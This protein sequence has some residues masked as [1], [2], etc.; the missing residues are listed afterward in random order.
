MM[1][2]NLSRE[3]HPAGHVICQIDDPGDCAYLVESGS[4]EVL[5]RSG[6]QLAILRAGEIVGEITQLDQ[7]PRPAT[8][9]TLETTVLLRIDR[10][11]VDEL[12]KRTDPVIRHLLTL[13]LERFRHRSD[14]TEPGEPSSRQATDLATTN[15]TLMMAQDLGYAMHNGQL[16]LAYQPLISLPEQRLLGFEALIRWQHPILGNISPAK[17][18]PLA[19]K[20]GMTEALGQWVLTQGIG[21]W[22]TLRQYCHRTPSPAPFISINLSAPE[23]ANP[24]IVETIDRLLA[25]NRM[26]ASELQLELI[27]TTLIDDMPAVSGNLNQLTAR[28]IGIALDDFGTGYASFEYLSTLPISCLKI[29]QAFILNAT[30][31]KRRREIVQM[32]INLARSLGMSTIGEGIEDEATG[33]LLAELGCNFAQGYF[34]GRPMALAAIPDWLS[35]A[36]ALGRLAP[37]EA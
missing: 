26:Q 17:L 10:K 23:L 19:E 18:I 28:G 37:A 12:L 16:S 29:D 4:I 30:H 3:T 8:I 11:H 21:D 22:P 6:K 34:F 25:A 13:L 14:G 9:R 32:A 20:T 36:R 2:E 35:E 1:Q 33:Q 5:G 15:L 27:E 7:R 24:A 31:D